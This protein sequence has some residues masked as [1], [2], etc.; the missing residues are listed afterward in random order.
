MAEK[1]EISDIQEELNALKNRVELL[2]I[3]A[4]KGTA[5]AE[6]EP[7]QR[8]KKVIQINAK[9]RKYFCTTPEEVQRFLDNNPDLKRDIQGEIDEV[10]ATE[11]YRNTK[12]QKHNAA[13]QKV[14]QLTRTKM[15]THNIH[16]PDH[17][18]DKYLNDPEN[19]KQFKEPE[20]EEIKV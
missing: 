17:V 10:K 4:K 13:I 20:L 16:L 14:A 2:E 9:G 15:E 19:K 6:S 3:I 5:A 12:N 1:Q 7:Q 11:A 18:A 8:T